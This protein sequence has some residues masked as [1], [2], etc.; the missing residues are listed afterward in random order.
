MSTTNN[1]PG[2]LDKTYGID[3]YTNPPEP[4]NSSPR[5]VV[6]WLN[7]ILFAP[8]TPD[9]VSRL[10]HFDGDGQRNLIFGPEGRRDVIP[11][12]NTGFLISSLISLS[13]GYIVAGSAKT[14]SG[15]GIFVVLKYLADGGLNEDFGHNGMLEV[16][17]DNVGN[18]SVPGA[19]TADGG[20]VIPIG[21]GLNHALLKVTRE[22]AVDTNFGPNKDGIVEFNLPGEITQIMTV[23]VTPDD[24]IL[25]VGHHL[26]GNYSAV[27]CLTSKGAPNS[28]YGEGGIGK[29]P[30]GVAPYYGVLGS[31]DGLVVCGGSNGHAMLAKLTPFG[32]IPSEFNEG[33]PVV[34]NSGVRV[35]VKCDVDDADRIL[36][37]GKSEEQFTV[38]RRYD[39]A[40]AQDMNYGPG[41]TWLSSEKN[42]D[43]L[44]CIFSTQKGA[45]M[46]T[47]YRARGW[48]LHP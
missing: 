6:K 46:S 38:A 29:L 2:H 35:W 4:N 17:L 14:P 23:V 43:G 1:Q 15:E 31:D 39:S 22:G 5:P 16:S 21:Q 9:S 8:V 34:D 18:C 26:F 33:N 45:V 28:S 30:S 3:G 25:V 42:F 24:Q 13:D 36:V 37:L 32:E 40:G 41:G 7:G 19:C 12:R 48:R 11:P 27:V 47:E 10:V 44:S 20:Y